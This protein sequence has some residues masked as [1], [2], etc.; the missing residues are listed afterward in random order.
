[1]YKLIPFKNLSSIR[2][3]IYK[4]IFNDLIHTRKPYAKTWHIQ[5]QECTESNI[6]IYCKSHLL[7]PVL[8]REDKFINKEI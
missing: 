4:Q 3:K 8:V 2:I 7:Y 6:F 1:M 5:G